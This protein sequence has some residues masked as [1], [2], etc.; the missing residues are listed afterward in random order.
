MKRRWCVPA[1]LLKSPGV[2]LE[3]EDVLAE[4]PGQ[5]GLLMWASVRDVYLWAEAEP[6][7]RAAVFAPEAAKG[8]LALIA[9]SPLP[10]EANLRLTQLAA[11]LLRTPQSV[12]VALIVES[13]LEL[14]RWAGDNHAPRAAVAFAQGAALADPGDPES[15][16]ETGIHSLAAGQI[17]RAETWL[18]RALSL[19]RHSGRVALIGPAYLNLAVAF[20]RQER[21]TEARLAALKALRATR[22]HGG[23][24]A[25]RWSVLHVLFLAAVAENNVV[26]AEQYARAA[27]EGMKRHRPG[28]AF[29]LD[30]AR[31]WCGND[32]TRAR[33]VLAVLLAQ[34]LGARERL[35]ALALMVRTAALVARDEFTAA[36]TAVQAQL[37]SMDDRDVPAEI[38]AHV[39]AAAALLF[40]GGRILGPPTG[41]EDRA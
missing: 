32:P 7:G 10:P 24:L 4:S 25:V 1:A 33:E 11:T 40:P 22:R 8:R 35:V 30:L 39:D 28:V 2:T 3:A 20:Q 41:G 26:H 13:C 18:R 6:A 19:A 31:W 27:A 21:H 9:R 37:R 23:G 14:A 36:W 17:A 34:D 16:L 29:L 38:A 5:L 12:P 15:A